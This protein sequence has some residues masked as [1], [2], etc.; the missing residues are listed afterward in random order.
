[1]INLDFSDRRPLYEQIK[2]KFKE[3]IISGA[4]NEHD[5]IPSVRELASSLAINP[6]TIQR[7][8]KELEEEGFIYSQRAKGSFVAPIKRAQTEEFI[9]ALYKNLQDAAAELLYRGESPEKLKQEVDKIFEHIKGV[10]IND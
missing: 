6:N 5:K 9:S 4:V 10:V 2:E 7:A 8:Y 3:L 1:M